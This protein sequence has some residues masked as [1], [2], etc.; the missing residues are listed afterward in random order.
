[1]TFNL[2]FFI[3]FSIVALF[4]YHGIFKSHR[5]SF[6]LVISIIF[7]TMLDYK[8]MLLLFFSIFLTYFMVQKSCANIGIKR[9]IIAWCAI[10]WL[11]LAL[12]FY[13]YFMGVMEKLDIVVLVILPVGI[14][15]YTFKMISYIAENCLKKES[16]SCQ[17]SAMEYAVYVSLFSQIVSGPISKISDLKLSSAYIGISKQGLLENGRL[18]I[19]GVF[20]KMVIADRL[21]VYT[22]YC[23]SHYSSMPVVALWMNVVF[24]S[25]QIYCDFCGYSE[26]AIGITRMFGLSCPDNFNLP[27]FSLTVKEFWHRWHI[28]LSTWL[29]DYIYIPLG[30]NR[31]GKWT[32]IR[33]VICVFVV[34]GLWHGNTL[35]F[36][37]WGLWHGLFQSLSPSLRSLQRWWQRLICRIVTLLAVG[38]GW[39][40]FYYSK[41]TDAVKYLW[42]LTG[43]LQLSVGV[44]IQSILPF[45]SDYSC[46]AHF[47]IVFIMIGI[48]FMYELFQYKGKKV[49]IG[50]EIVIDFIFIV[51]FGIFGTNN[52]I[53]ANY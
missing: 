14:S 40:F 37:L 12:C 39:I 3:M 29:K 11:L 10:F 51:M 24:F 1:M 42:S 45:S 9:K 44:I 34:S 41:L 31:K 36:L 23:F 13:K 18:I 52:F 28:S 2:L 33:N 17:Y 20:K 53:Y 43:K 26:V 27:Y 50:L 16:G 15:Y 4:L 32:G 46:F 5:N 48:L 47:G 38:I 35:N 30:G 8:H 49:D 7:Y 21:A 25:I 19:S 6:L 22:N